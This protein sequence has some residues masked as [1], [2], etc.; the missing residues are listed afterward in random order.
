MARTREDDRF[1]SVA[2]DSIVL[3]YP[4]SQ[5]DLNGAFKDIEY[6]IWLDW[7]FVEFWK[8]GFCEY[9]YQYDSTLQIIIPSRYNAK[10]N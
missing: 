4:G 3:P 9:N 1:K 6:E 2:P 8:S 7:S 5:P 10:S